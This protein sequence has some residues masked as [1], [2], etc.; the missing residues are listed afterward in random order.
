MDTMDS[1]LPPNFITSQGLAAYSRGYSFPDHVLSMWVLEVMSVCLGKKLRQVVTYKQAPFITVDSELL[2]MADAILKQVAAKNL[3]D[4]KG[5]VAVVTGGGT[6]IGLMISTTLAANG[7]DVYIIGPKQENLDR[8]AKVYN[9]AAPNN[10]VGQGLLYGVEGDV[11]VKSEA[12]RLANVIGSKAGHVTVLFNNAGISRGATH[13]PKEATAEAYV[14]GFFDPLTQEDW[15]KTFNTNTV[16]PYWMTFAF[17]PL[18]E[19]WKRSSEPAAAKFCPAGHHD[20]QYEWMDKAAIAQAT[21]SLAHE[22]LPLSIRVNSI[23]PGVFATEMAGSQM[24][25]PGTM[26]TLGK[27]RDPKELISSVGMQ[28][29]AGFT[30]T[31]RDVGS[32]AL[33]LVTN[34]YIN[35]ETVLVDGGVKFPEAS[36]VVLTLGIVYLVS[37]ANHSSSLSSSMADAILDRLTANNIFDLHGVVAVVTGGGTGIGLMISTTL[38]ANGAT[39]YIIGPKQDDLD[40]IAKV[41]NDAAAQNNISGKLIG[42]EGDIRW[43]AEA[44]RLAEEIGKREKHVT[45]LFNNA[46][47][48]V[49]QYTKPEEATADAFV[50][51]Y[52]DT[53]TQEDFENS[54]HTNAIGP[55]WLSFAFLPLLEKWKNSE[56]AK[57]FVPQIIM[58]SSMNGWTKASCNLRLSATM[59]GL[60]WI[61]W[62][63]SDTAGRSFPYMFSKSA[64]GH[65]TS[66]LA[67]ELLPLGIRLLNAHLFTLPYRCR[68]KGSIDELGQSHSNKLH[69]FKVPTEPAGSNRDVGSLAL[70]LVSNWFINGETVLIDG[71]TLLVHASSY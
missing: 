62:Q 37:L 48:L 53:V 15:N 6:G 21:G 3:F 24:T 69:P 10:P 67:H 68:R 60:T 18:L 5:V 17:L 64:I 65:A 8:I 35:G 36:V 58:T 34:W 25:S 16:G 44:K 40:K 14:K 45:V 50:K 7:A 4:L 29:P 9:D 20:D 61:L 46:G 12:T 70:M 57:K 1:H 38:V 41:Y 56:L 31:I 49:G 52:F 23:A 59:P 32:V 27:S 71:G 30:G 54:L 39:V 47:V 42:L 13:P 43:K 51:G 63:D 66:S 26:D 11:S 28:I 19:K 33:M 2:T 22:L 55:Y